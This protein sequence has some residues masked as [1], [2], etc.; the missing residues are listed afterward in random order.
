MG[1]ITIVDFKGRKIS[2]SGLKFVEPPTLGANFQI[3][4]DRKIEKEVLLDKILRR[5]FES[6]AN[7][8]VKMTIDMIEKKCKVFDNLFQLMF[9]KGAAAAFVL[10]QVEGL[11]N[12][13]AKDIKVMEIAATMAFEKA[14]QAICAARKEWR[15]FKIKIF[16]NI[17]ASLA[18]LAISLVALASTPFTGGASAAFAI[19]GM[20]KSATTIAVNAGKLGTSFEDAHSDLM[21]QLTRLEKIAE[22]KGLMAANEI[23]AAVFTEF[24]GKAQTNIKSCQDGFAT[25]RATYAKLVIDVHDLS[26]TIS[27]I[28][29]ERARL[30]KEF[31]AEVEKR[32]KAHPTSKK[33][34]QKKLISE[35]WRLALVDMDSMVE[36][37]SNKME[38]MYKYV[39]DMSP[40]LAKVDK[41]ITQLNLKDL[42]GVKIFREALKLG[43][44]ALSPLDGNAL[45]TKAYDLQFN[46]SVSASSYAYDK[47]TAKALDGSCFDV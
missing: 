7:A 46:I 19:V 41:R 15:N 24:L 21:D 47:L 23:T 18:T 27:K 40:H 4:V 37:K 17:A 13:L 22:S 14:W 9:D 39:K 32:L 6:E 29:L 42:K 35:N 28:E 10:Q 8:I 12:A 5:E 33:S 31:L 25:M 45:A 38:G 1:K 26:K 43:S 11:N 34:V 36:E 44:V 2:G 3:E 20:V 30:E 16:A